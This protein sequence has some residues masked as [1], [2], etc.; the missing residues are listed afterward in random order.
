MRFLLFSDVHRDLNA[1]GQLVQKSRDVDVVVGAGDFCTMRKGLDEVIQA[2]AAIACPAV[3]VPGNSESA[4]ELATACQAWRA[5]HVLHGSGVEIDGI[6]FW[7]AGGAIPATPFGS[8]SYDFS[9]AEG[10]QLLAGCPQRGVIVSHSPPQGFVDQS[11]SGQSLG[12]V[13]VR[14]TVDRC[15]PVLVVCGHIHDSGGQSVT[16]GNTVVVNAGP[17]GIVWELSDDAA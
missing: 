9:E 7:G 11:S 13:A 3:V 17:E 16:V 8:W 15:Q 2:L 4:E 6:Q 12:S 1:A 10:R 5:A 14:E